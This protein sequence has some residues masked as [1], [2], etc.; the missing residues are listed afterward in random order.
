GKEARE[1]AALDQIGS[2]AKNLAMKHYNEATEQYGKL[3]GSDDAL[4]KTLLTMHGKGEAEFRKYL[5]DMF[6]I[7]AQVAGGGM[8]SSLP[9]YFKLENVLKEAQKKFARGDDAGGQK[10]IDD[11]KKTTYF[12]A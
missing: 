11:F 4:L 7:D 1:N 12:G 8:K 2:K 5:E 10:L 9:I 3:T 6:G